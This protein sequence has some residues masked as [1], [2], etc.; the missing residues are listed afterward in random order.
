MNDLVIYIYI[1]I[2]IY[3]P[4][5][6]HT[7]MSKKVTSF[8]LVFFTNFCDVVMNFCGVYK[9]ILVKNYCSDIVNQLCYEY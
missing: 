7:S 8:F 1:Y 4:T 6:I 2:F 5:T 3:G 9:A